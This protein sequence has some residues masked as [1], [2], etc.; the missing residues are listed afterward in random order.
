MSHIFA[1][2]VPVRSPRLSSS[3]DL[4]VRDGSA[5]LFFADEEE[6]RDHLSVGEI[7]DEVGLHQLL[8]FGSGNFFFSFFLFAASGVGATS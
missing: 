2:I 7:D 1:E 3:Q 8:T 6:R 4:P 5:N